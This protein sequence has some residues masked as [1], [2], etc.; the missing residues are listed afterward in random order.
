MDQLRTA[1]VSDETLTASQVVTKDLPINPV[2]HLNLTLKGLNVTDETT[3]AEVLAR[4]SKIT[5]SRLG[6]AQLDINGADLFALNCVMFGNV[7]IL[8]NRV[9]ADNSTRAITMLLPFGRR[10]YDPKE[11]Y[12]GTRRGEFKIQITISATETAIDGLILQLE[13]VEL[14]GATPTRFLKV[15]T[16]SDT[17]GA[18]GE[19]DLD[20]PI[21]NQIAGLLL[22]STTVP[23]TTAWT[24]T[25]EK[26]KLLK[27][28]TENQIA[29]AQWEALHGE[30]LSR[31]GYRGD[32]AAA[33][34]D[35]LIHKYGLL[36][37]S[38]DWKDDFLLETKGLSSLKTVATIGDTNLYRVLPLEL[39]KV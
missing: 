8:T 30:I 35:D 1:I 34:G 7:P 20:L 17:P 23:A 28:N 18:T 22:F 3:L 19:F 14:L 6:E 13:A 36:D 26:I 16:L 32:Y 9:A 33:S 15:R 39:V 27:N 25:I 10:L 21:G 24:A 2:S 12:P 38:P 4:L 11:C 37:F 5:I 29:A 31:I